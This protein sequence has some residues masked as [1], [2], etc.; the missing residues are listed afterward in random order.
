MYTNPMIAKPKPMGRESVHDL[1][2]P[3]FTLPKTAKYKIK[4][5]QQLINPKIIMSK[6]KSHAPAVVSI[7]E[8]V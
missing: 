5:I 4:I 1:Y 6:Y 2:R 7:C 3:F 8:I